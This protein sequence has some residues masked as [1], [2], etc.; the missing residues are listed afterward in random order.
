MELKPIALTTQPQL[1]A[2]PASLAFLGNW[3]F[4]L[5]SLL[6][7]N[8]GSIKKDCVIYLSAMGLVVHSGHCVTKDAKV[9]T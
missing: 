7:L 8:M 5:K 3:I 1:H 4:A 6:T 9:M 2:A